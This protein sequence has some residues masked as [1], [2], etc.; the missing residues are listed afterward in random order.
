L[1]IRRLQRE[2]RAR[3][4]P[5]GRMYACRLK[6]FFA[7]KVGIPLAGARLDTRPRKVEYIRR[8]GGKTTYFSVKINF[9][10][11]LDLSVGSISYNEIQASGGI[12]GMMSLSAEA[13]HHMFQKQRRLLS[14]MVKSSLCYSG[15]VMGISNHLFWDW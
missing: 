15:V 8:C 9:F 3:R 4:D 7:D 2:V 14:I 10:S 1:N 11:V 6:P 12:L 5:A 13:S